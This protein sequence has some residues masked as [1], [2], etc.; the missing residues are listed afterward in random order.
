MKHIVSILFVLLLFGCGGSKYYILSDIKSQTTKGSY[1][2]DNSIGVEKIDVPKYLFKRELA[3]LKSS[4]EIAF[5]S[6]TEWAE[7]MD[8]ALSRRVVGSLQKIFHNP[9]ISAYPWGVDT[10]P[11]YILHIGI[12]KFIA[13]NNRV[14][15][16]A[17]YR[18]LDTKRDRVKSYIF[19]KSLPMSDNKPST[20]I[21]TMDKIFEE[22]IW[23]IAHRIK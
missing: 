12:T 5:L 13:F 7:D 18:I 3:Y 22:F 20:I 6:D 17:T 19:D 16:Y 8:E 9:N 1:L 14:Y 4:N 10:Q 21:A 15:L 2:F 11:E 23:D